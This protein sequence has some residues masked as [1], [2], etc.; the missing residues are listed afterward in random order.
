MVVL[1]W[2]ANYV[3]IA[4]FL[5]V[6]SI[7]VITIGTSLSA[8]FSSVFHMMDGDEGELYRR[9][10]KAYKQNLRQGI[11]AALIIAVAAFLWISGWGT[12]WQYSEGVYKTILGV[13][14]IFGMAFFWILS[15]YVFA[16]IGRYETD[17]LQRFKNGVIFAVGK[18]VHSF[19]L[20]V[21]TAVLLAAGYLFPAIEL[22]VFPAS[23]FLYGYVIR[24]IFI[25]YETSE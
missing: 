6:G 5:L 11:P 23:L 25:N 12:L 24:R 19:L 14:T 17:L 8:A 10:W 7:P 22:L 2:I 4:F 15:L 9:F 3:V 21:I 16:Q 1:G 20:L 18:P 13:M